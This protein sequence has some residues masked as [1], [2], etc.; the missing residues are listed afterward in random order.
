MAVLPLLRHA[1]SAA[2]DL[3][4]S[5]LGLGIPVLPIEGAR[6]YAPGISMGTVGVFPAFSTPSPAARSRGAVV[7][8]GRDS[9][10]AIICVFRI[11]N[12]V[13]Y[14]TIWRAWLLPAG[15]W[16]NGLTRLSEIERSQVR[17]SVDL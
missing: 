16:L 17:D 3:A 5:S 7:A 9:A 12:T 2:A 8:R 11:A 4:A 6:T 14:C 15:A 10:P 1:E 13:I